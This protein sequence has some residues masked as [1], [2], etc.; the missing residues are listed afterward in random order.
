M[1]RANISKGKNTPSERRL[2][3]PTEKK[4]KTDELITSTPIDATKRTASFMDESSISLHN[5]D[6]DAIVQ[7]AIKL[8]IDLYNEK[9]TNLI[10]SKLEDIKKEINAINENLGKKTTALENQIERIEGE[11]FLLDKQIECT[12]KTISQL[13][14]ENSELKTE[15]TL[16][17]RDIQTNTI[18]ANRNEQYSRKNSIRI[19]GIAQNSEQEDCKQIVQEFCKQSLNINFEKNEIVGAHRVGR[20]QPDRPQGIIVKFV[21]SETK[22]N[23]IKARRK[24]KGTIYV[25]NDDLSQKNAQ[26]LNRAHRHERV[27]STW[28]SNGKLFAMGH[29]G[30]KIR[31]EL[32]CDI[33]SLLDIAIHGY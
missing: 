21:H 7:D 15:L 8:A 31:L 26:L 12:N 19:F 11:K 30:A 25:V 29:N 5:A 10:T 28:S 22:Y 23:I 17:N 1:N 4:Q 6:I 2:S 32:F 24:L 3:K 9:I 14:T 27:K 18:A 33:D 20:K 16:I 13:K